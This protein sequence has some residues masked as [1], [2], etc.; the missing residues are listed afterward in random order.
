MITCKYVFNCEEK[1]RKETSGFSGFE[2]MHYPRGITSAAE[3]C[4]RYNANVSSGF[5]RSKAIEPSVI[6]L[7]N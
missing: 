6:I 3:G 7:L 4:N 2:P 1:N 5:K